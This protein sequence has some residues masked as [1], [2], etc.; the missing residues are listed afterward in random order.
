MAKALSIEDWKAPL[1]G[2]VNEEEE[3][4]WGADLVQ[5]GVEAALGLLLYSSH[6]EGSSVNVLFFQTQKLR[7]IEV[8]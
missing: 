5:H 8:T 6:P 3:A 2:K 1:M 4:S 7:H